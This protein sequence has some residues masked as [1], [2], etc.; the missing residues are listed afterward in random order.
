MDELVRPD[1]A[2]ADSGSS[3]DSEDYPIS[4]THHYHDQDYDNDSEG[5]VGFTPGSTLDGITPLTDL[6]SPPWPTYL[7]SRIRSNLSDG[8][9]TSRND[10]GSPKPARPS[11]PARQISNTYQPNRNPI[12]KSPLML[13]NGT[14]HRSFSA[15]RDLR[16][17]RDPSAQYRAQEKAYIR[18]LR[19]DPFPDYFENREPYTP[20]IDPSNESDAEIESPSSDIPID[21]DLFDEDTQLFYHQDADRPSLEEMQVPENRERLEWHSM[22][23]SVLKG[24]VVTQEKQ[25][26]IGSQEQKSEKTLKSELWLGIRARVCGRSPAAQRR[27]VE[28]GRNKI[29]P[30]IEAIINFSVKGEAE[31]GKP[32]ADQVMDVVQNIEKCESLFPTRMAL[33]EAVERAAS[34]A[35][36]ES[37]EAVISWHNTTQLINTQLSILRSWVGN[38]ELDFTK[39]NSTSQQITTLRDDTSFLER[40]NKDDSLIALQGDE[41]GERSM[42][43]PVQTTIK[44]AK[45]SLIQNAEHFAKRHLPP[46]MEELLTLINFPVRLIQEFIRMRLQYALKMKD[47]ASLEPLLQDQM[48]SQFQ[49]LLRL[50]IWYKQEYNIIAQSEPGWELPPCIDENFDSVILDALK[51][52]FKMLNGKLVGNRNTFKEA[53]ILES[54]W[55]FC[56]DIGRNLAGGDVEVAEQFSGLTAKALQR[57]TAHFEKE[58]TRKGEQNA[59]EMSKRH[60]QMLDSVRVRQRKL[61]RFSRLLGQRF[62]NATEF[63]ISLGPKRMQQLHDALIDSQHFLIQF[64]EQKVEGIYY[65]GSSGLYENIGKVRSI[66]GTSQYDEYFSDDPQPPYVLTIRPDE[67]LL[68]EGKSIDVNMRPPPTDVR[69]GRLRLVTDGS[70]QRLQNARSRFVQSINMDLPILTEM[71]ANLPRVNLELGKIKKTAYKLSNTIMDSVG[72]IQEQTKGLD[73]QELVQTCFAFATEFGKRSVT[74][75]DANRRMMNNMKLTR[76]ALDW[77]SFICDDCIASDRKTFKWAVTALEFAM[78][79][80]SG[81]S[82]L[83]VTAQEF[84]LLRDKVAGCMALLISHFDIMGAK[85]TLAARAEKQRMESVAGQFRKMDINKMKDDAEASKIT[86]EQWLQS[87]DEIEDIRKQ[88]IAERQ[89]LGRVME[90][91]NDADRSLTYLSSNATNVTMR[92]QLGQYVGGGTFGSVYAAFNIDSGSLM[93][94]K[95]IRLQDPQMIPQVASQIRDEQKVLEVLDHPNIVSYYGIEVHRDKVYIFMEYCS[96]G[97]LASLLEHGRIE[98]ETVVQVYALQMLEGLAYL[99]QANITH[100][101][102]K[103]ESKSL[104]NFKQGY[105]NRV[106]DILLDHNGVIKFVDFGAAK[107]IARQNKTLQV[108]PA[109]VTGGPAA[110]APAKQKSMTGT[111]MYMS[112]EVIKGSGEGRGGSRLGAVDI[113]SLGCVVLEMATGR[114]PWATLDNEWAIMYNIAQGNS[115]QLPTQD[116]LSEDGIEFLRRCFEKDPRRRAT[117]AELLQCEWISIIKA[118]VVPLE[119]TSPTDR[120]SSTTSS[121]NSRQNSSIF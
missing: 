27:M 48:I 67:P 58:L 100:R 30:E 37:S 31:A 72:I 51:F 117:A 86:R 7:Q 112:P 18:Q 69:P 98:D 12:Q 87:L 57:L 71:R 28:E 59:F 9:D 29:I 2:R 17:K 102:I 63:N 118:Q 78:I 76:L 99:H 60:K 11:G 90:D 19:Q 77:V 1:P 91:T 96:G 22:L 38:D 23:A 13:A 84:K 4:L 110:K 14:R 74:Y 81:P 3:T 73:N 47:P 64:P 56:N 40:L 65:L 114:R 62:E 6:S 107:V 52:Y 103:P 41:K 83:H 43:K 92:W 94:V 53:E 80:T 16:L 35:F 93:A 70:L 42:I 119:E 32:A 54:E 104:S 50:A 20:S 106:S 75:M 116:Q 105:A 45:T 61:F 5:T 33:G 85:L 115:P 95:E 49:I 111:P 108:D 25:R 26:L 120:T 44:K 109:P 101:D 46:Y 82:I 113:W 55:E 21:G 8:Q 79:M 97:S 89:A 34:R 10:V 121:T 36:E 39:V 88:K 68:W 24:D 15:T 66:L